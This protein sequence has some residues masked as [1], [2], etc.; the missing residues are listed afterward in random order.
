[1]V[2]E[3]RALRTSQKES[4]EQL[5]FSIWKWWRRQVDSR[6][7]LLHTGTW[8]LPMWSAGWSLR[9]YTCIHVLRDERANLGSAIPS[10]KLGRTLKTELREP[11][12]APEVLGLGQCTFWWWRIWILNCQRE[13]D[14]MN[15]QKRFQRCIRAIFNIRETHCSS[16]WK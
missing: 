8:A 1:M 13:M 4:W 7:T 5:T 9:V 11:R 14:I 6:A 3:L 15:E 12:T 16:F 10:E 2:P